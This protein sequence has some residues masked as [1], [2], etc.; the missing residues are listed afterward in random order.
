MLMFLSSF[1]LDYSL[2]LRNIKV[3]LNNIFKTYI[4]KLESRVSKIKIYYKINT[5]E[6]F[7]LVC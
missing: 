5:I 6:E 7:N 3:I 1:Y 2:Y 4:Q